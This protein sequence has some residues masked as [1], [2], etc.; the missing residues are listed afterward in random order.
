M[1]EYNTDYKITYTNLN[2][3]DDLIEQLNKEFVEDI[4]YK[5]DMLNIFHLKEYNDEIVSNILKNVYNKIS[6]DKTIHKCIKKIQELNPFFND[7]E[8]AAFMVL[9]A[10]DNLSITHP[11][12]CE[13]LKTGNLSDENLTNL[14][15][16]F[17]L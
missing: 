11:C 6:N 1:C 2:E 17:M 13:L 5:N 12:I 9:F 10:F 15:K 16:L 4:L 14:N 3:Y 8:F 7:D